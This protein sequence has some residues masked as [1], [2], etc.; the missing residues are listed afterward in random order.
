MLSN[1]PS[2]SPTVSDGRSSHDSV[3]E[4]RTAGSDLGTDGVSGEDTPVLLD[5]PQ[6]PSGAETNGSGGEVATLSEGRAASELEEGRSPVE[7]AGHE[8]EEA[9][10]EE[11]GS[12]VEEGEE[13]A[14]ALGVPASES[15]LAWLHHQPGGS[16]NDGCHSVP[17]H[18][19]ASMSTPERLTAES[20]STS[21]WNVHCQPTQ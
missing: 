17:E 2:P 20:S 16:Q 8:V 7:E 18:V 9:E 15:E 12:T 10:V 11:L 19:D 3:W 5:S 4:C 13:A 6:P 14:L 21:E 1:P